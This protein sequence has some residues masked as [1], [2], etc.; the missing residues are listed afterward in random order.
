[1]SAKFF[2]SLTITLITIFQ[3][4]FSTVA[5]KIQLKPNDDKI[6]GTKQQQNQIE[7]FFNLKSKQ[8]QLI[9]A[10]SEVA[11]LE[12]AKRKIQINEA[13]FES[14]QIYEKADK[15]PQLI[16]SKYEQANLF[17]NAVKLNLQHQSVFF[18]KNAEQNNDLD[19]LLAM[20]LYRDE[21]N[22]SISHLAAKDNLSFVKK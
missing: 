7:Q 12:F 4:V 13:E 1:M 17:H 20:L 14:N 5:L 15:V 22:A 18:L 9:N 16:M 19:A 6:E 3:I 8:L 2:R 21:N 10:T 11:E